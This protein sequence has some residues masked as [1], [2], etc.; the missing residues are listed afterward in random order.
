MSLLLHSRFLHE[1]NSYISVAH[2]L[3][4]TKHM[5]L[6]AARLQVFDFDTYAG[7]VPWAEGRGRERKGRTIPLAK[8]C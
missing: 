1:E 3:Q 4:A 2:N 5:S 7:A 8:L 6:H